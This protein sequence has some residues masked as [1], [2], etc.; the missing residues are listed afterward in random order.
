MRKLLGL[1][2]EE[3]VSLLKEEGLSYSI[4]LTEAPDHHS[5]SKYENRYP[6]VIKQDIENG[7]YKLTVS[8]VPDNYW[9]LD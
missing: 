2:E 5:P 1:M 3:A 7:T 9:R 8:M 6:R 4:K